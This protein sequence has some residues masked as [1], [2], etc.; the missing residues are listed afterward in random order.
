MEV[1][2][3]VLII[4]LSFGSSIAFGQITI[5]TGDG[6]LDAELNLFSKN[7]ASDPVSAKS[8]ITS[9][10]NITGTKVES[11]LGNAMDYAEILLSAKMADVLGIPLDNVLKSY[12]SNKEKGWGAI[13]KDLGIKPG[14]AEFHALKGKKGKGN[15]GKGNSGK[16]NSKGK[17]K[18]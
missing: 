18:S 11:L 14:S 6:T 7:A 13:A 4:A 5:S 17:G 15:S 1:K 16:G 8:S 3:L 10:Y 2:K 9:N 12:E